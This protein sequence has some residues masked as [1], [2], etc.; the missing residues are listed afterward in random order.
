[1][2][3]DHTEKLLAPQ[4]NALVTAYGLPQGG[5]MDVKRKAFRRFIGIVSDV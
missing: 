1:M 4:L 5:S 2:Q 3:T